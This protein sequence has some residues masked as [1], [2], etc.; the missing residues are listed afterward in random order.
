MK[1]RSGRNMRA[2]VW[3]DET[4]RNIHVPVMVKII[5]IAPGTE[6]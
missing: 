2:S 1:T 4:R 6:F 5:R 3:S